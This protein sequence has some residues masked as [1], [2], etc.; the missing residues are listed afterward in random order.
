MTVFLAVG[1]CLDLL[2]RKPPSPNSGLLVP[3]SGKHVVYAVALMSWPRNNCFRVKN[4][5][6]VEFKTLANINGSTFTVVWELMFETEVSV[7]GKKRHFED[8]FG[9][10]WLLTAC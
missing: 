7:T 4:L 3:N 5:A 9:G 2:L 10:F 8:R 6:N 1:D